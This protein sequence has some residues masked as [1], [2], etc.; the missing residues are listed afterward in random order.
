MIKHLE[1]KYK[2]DPFLRYIMNNTDNNIPINEGFKIIKRITNDWINQHELYNENSL[3]SISAY[4]TSLF[5][6][7]GNKTLEEYYDRTKINSSQCDKGIH[8]DAWGNNSMEVHIID[9]F[10]N[11][12][13]IT[14][15][16]KCI[17]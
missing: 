16:T 8:L 1:N 9:L 5:T 10:W 14:N 12:T 15:S 3:D 2:I 11:E 13:S 4:I 6:S 17:N 7:N